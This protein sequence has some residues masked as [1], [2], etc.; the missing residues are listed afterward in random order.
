MRSA[1]NPDANR[2]EPPQRA[3]P[4]IT[5]RR[6]LELHRRAAA[7]SSPDAPSPRTPRRRCLDPDPDACRRLE[8]SS[9]RT[10]VWSLERSTQPTE[11]GFRSRLADMKAYGVPIKATPMYDE[12]P[13]YR[14]RLID[15]VGDGIVLGWSFGTP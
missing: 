13:D 12:I 4:W 1:W 8:S 6:R 14:Y 10:A 11:I 5:T 2:L 3:A 9:T 7:L 15:Y